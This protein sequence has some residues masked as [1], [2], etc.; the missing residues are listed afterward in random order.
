MG[1]K[2]GVLIIHGMG[3]QP[4]EFSTGLRDELQDRLGRIES[5]FKWV[6]IYWAEILEKREKDLL[7]LMRNAETEDKQTIDLDWIPIR[8]FVV[9]YF[10]D[11][12]AYQRD[13]SK[14]RSAYS[15]VHKLISESVH[16][17]NNELDDPEAPVIVLAHSLGAH[18]MSNYIWDQQHGTG[19]ALTPIPNLLTMITFGCNIPLFSLAFPVAKPIA[20]PGDGITKASLI[21]VSKWLNFLDSDDVLGWPLKPLYKKNL[22]QLSP[23]QKKTVSRIVDKE[24]SV[25]SLF[26]SWNPGAH[27]GYWTDNDFTK[28]VATYL[29]QVV[30]ALDR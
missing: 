3:R 12:L 9:H 15:L 24:I 16:N 4:D 13:I 8:K 1:R 27:T 19:L 17:L 21:K 5:R 7:K 11:A 26:T 23:K 25:G 28:P 10:G 2:I 14:P 18:M 6:D 29:A 20:I 22:T 30:D